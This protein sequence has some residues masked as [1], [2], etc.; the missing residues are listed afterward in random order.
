MYTCI[1]V[2][3]CAHANRW[4]YVRAYMYVYP[5]INLSMY[6]CMSESINMAHT[7]WDLKFFVLELNLLLLGLDVGGRR[8]HCSTRNECFIFQHFL[9]VSSPLVCIQCCNH[10][11]GAIAMSDVHPPYNALLK[12]KAVLLLCLLEITI[13]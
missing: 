12:A 2:S 5:S 7:T 3:V 8:V 13:S 4:G 9:V 6:T 10:C 11:S 1:C